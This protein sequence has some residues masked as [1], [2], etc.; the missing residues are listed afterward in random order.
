KQAYGL[1]Y[2]HA[3]D[4][5][6]ASKSNSASSDS[7]DSQSGS[8]D[9][10]VHEQAA[11]EAGRKAEIDTVRHLL[12]IPIDHFVEVTLGAF[13]QLA[14]VVAPI[15]V[16]LNADTSDPYSGADFHAGVQHID[17]A[18]AMAFVRQRR[19]VNDEN[20]TDLDRTRR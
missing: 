11:R 20:F 13:F 9:P 7:V 4:S 5:F 8:D 1:A 17:A 10:A 16:C 3:M 15:T 19:D 14:Q 6:S 12:G 18:Q 2:L